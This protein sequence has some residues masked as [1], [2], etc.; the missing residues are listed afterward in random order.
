MKHAPHIIVL[1]LLALINCFSQDCNAQDVLTQHNDNSR[2]GANLGESKLTTSNVSV[3]GF[4]K[5]AEWPVD[6]HIYA[7]PLYV[8][9]VKTRSGETHNIVYVATMNNSVYA[10]DADAS[11]PSGQWLWWTTGSNAI[12]LP[13]PIIY[14]NKTNNIWLKIGIVSTPVISKQHNALYAVTAEKVGNVYLHWLHAL[15][16]GSGAELFGGPILI[17]ASVPGSGD[18]SVSG[19]VPFVSRHQNQRP[20]LLLGNDVVYVAFASY[21]DGNFG[22]QPYHGWMLAYSASTLAFRTAFNTTPNGKQGAIW[23]AGQGPA[24]D[25]QNNIYIMTGNGSF[26]IAALTDK[27]V[28]SE[29]A[30]GAPALANVAD[31]SLVIAWTGTNVFHGPGSLNVASSSDGKSFGGKVTLNETSIDGPG[32]AFGNGHLFIAWAGMNVGHS[33]NVIS[34]TD[35]RSFSNKVTL[36][37]SSLFGP[38]LAFGN[39]RLFLAW[40]GTDFNHSL[41]VM[42]STDGKT[43]SNKVTLNESSFAAP[44]LSFVNGKLFLLWRGTDPNSSLNVMESTDGINFSNKLTLKDSSDFAPAIAQAGFLQV[45]GLFLAWTGQDPQHR[46][47]NLFADAIPN[48]FGNKQTYADSSSGAPALANFQGK[49]FIAWS[50]TDLPSH[51]NIAS[52]VNAPELGY[53]FAK[54]KSDL[55]LTD[56]FSPYQTPELWARNSDL[57]LGSGGV[58]LL[59]ESELLVGGGKNENIYV[60]DRRNLGHICGTCG[61][62]SGDTQI[63]QWFR[64]SGVPLLGRCTPGHPAP[65]AYDNGIGYHHIHGS[66]VYWHSPNRGPLIYIWAEGDCM[67]AFRFDGSRFDPTPVDVTQVNTPDKSMPGAILSLSA[68]GSTAGSGIIWASH[69]FV[70]DANE[71]LQPGIVR[72]F[73]ATDL[74][75]EL[76]TS[77]Q[78]SARDSLGNVSKFSPVTIANG[79]VFVPTFSNKLVVYG[80]LH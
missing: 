44:A 65:N 22:T 21:A 55:S 62:G 64:A 73:D 74:T 50:G 70:G 35:L 26:S 59:P 14:G 7:Q 36:S 37:E 18:L 33:L 60:L 51:V 5:V 78:N 61:A 63:V 1:F 43:F 24:A 2:T 12:N 8:S 66:P 48:Q 58:L 54:L 13:D 28:L 27:T 39:G 4:G 76:W 67:R 3:Q 23:Q 57:D 30:I 69:P 46:L 38:A 79:K 20:A 17:Q 19:Q 72:A 52:I 32:L 31:N 68:N 80:L 40:V 71:K 15:D 41:N 16:L 11:N 42:S 49:L 34:S 6:G 47:N 9:G 29:T 10:F 25:D 56:W 77:E 45:G 53:S 75:K